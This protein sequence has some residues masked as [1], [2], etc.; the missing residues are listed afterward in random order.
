MDAKPVSSGVTL[1]SWWSVWLTVVVAAW[2]SFISISWVS[3]WWV[4][5][6]SFIPGEAQFID[7]MLGFILF[8]G[9][10]SGTVGAALQVASGDR[11]PRLDH[12][13]KMLVLAAA[14]Y[15]WV[16]A[17]KVLLPALAETLICNLSV[18]AISIVI[19]LTVL[20]RVR[21][22]NLKNHAVKQ[23]NSAPPAYVLQLDS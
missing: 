14:I 19:V 7:Q 8:I 10:A 15:T 17:T 21:D 5:N 13:G 18:A 16:G 20:I 11:Q 6:V 4:D 3:A 9:A 1:T 2:A 22:R 23:R 12:G